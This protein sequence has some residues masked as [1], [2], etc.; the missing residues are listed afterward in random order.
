MNLMK[1]SM[2]IKTLQIFCDHNY[3]SNIR[4]ITEFSHNIIEY[5]AGYIVISSN[6]LYLLYIIEYIAGYIVENNFNELL[7]FLRLK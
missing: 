3:V 4:E 6:I 2:K 7:R 5:I 1:I